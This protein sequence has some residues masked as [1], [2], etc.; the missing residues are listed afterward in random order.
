MKN[1]SFQRRILNSERSIVFKELH[2]SCIIFSPESKNPTGAHYFCTG[3]QCYSPVNRPACR[4]IKG[5]QHQNGT[6]FQIR[7]PPILPILTQRKK[8]NHL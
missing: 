6:G 4:A 3:A 2:F 1:N 8:L 7:T 5:P